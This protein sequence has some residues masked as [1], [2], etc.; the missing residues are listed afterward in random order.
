VSE[1]VS[2]PPAVPVA[3]PAGHG[4]RVV[5]YALLGLA[6]ALLLLTTFAVWIDRVALDTNQFVDT[7]SALVEDDAIRNAIATRAVDELYANVDVQAELQKQAPKDLK[8]LSGVAAAGL[9]QGAYIVAD[10]ALQQPSLQGVWRTTL[11]QTHQ[12]L[13]NVLE[14]NGS[15]V[16]TEQGVVTLDLRPIVLDTADRIGIR[17]TVEDKLPADVA[18]IEV[19]RS[20]ELHAAQAVFQLLKTLAWFL[21]VLMLLVFAVAVFLARGRRRQ[22]LRD[23][24]IV[25]FVAAVVG[26]VAVGVTGNYVVDALTTDTE[27]QAAGNDAWHIVTGLLRSSLYL[28]LVVGV[29]IVVGAWLAG[30][31]RSAVATRR[32]IS[33][34]LRERLYPYAALA[35]VA[36]VLLVS[37]PVQDFARLLF[38]FVIV[39]LLAAGIEV[40]RAQ[41]LQEFPGAAMSSALAETRARVS[42][43]V[44]ALRTPRESP[45]AAEP[46]PAADFTAQLRE[47]AELHASGAL[48]DEEYG[49]AKARVLAGG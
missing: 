33:P 10:R 8:S 49:A 20:D 25:I 42:E 29:V 44:A 9:R 31:R 21:P 47:L 43:W 19:L 13:V 2:T 46:Q 23:A 3:R 24:G 40:L 39:A 6:G 11:R 12:E 27:T 22:A 38:V 36:L 16:S 14:G 35:V 5:V 26:L 17:N 41:A 37:A 45:R 32:V 18:R 15:T 28:Q 1:Q 30:P 4:R 34:L 7:S 48:T